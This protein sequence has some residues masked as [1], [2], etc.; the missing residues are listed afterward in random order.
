MQEFVC[1]TGMILKQIPIAEYD[2][3]VCILTKERGKIAAFARGARKPN[4]RLAAATNP[5]C[6]GTFKLY[7]GRDSYT[8]ADAEIQNYF[9][10]L[11]TDY[12]GAYYGMYFA[13]VADYYTRE[14]NDEK[15]MLKL[16]YQSLRALSA[17]SLSRTL[18]KCIYELKAIAVNGEFPG[19][20]TDRKLEESTVYALRYIEN[21]PV[22]K[23]YTFTVT[24]S[25]L[26]ELSKVAE[27]YRKRFMD[28]SF[29]S[30]EILKTL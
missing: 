13:E 24:A 14:N 25:V 12:E 6:F 20:P 18:V 29:K 17:P 26:T 9:E 28:R 2:R 1:V 23:L 11:M 30:L 7:V 4:S 8:M 22:E 15:E 16:L 27:D 5:F 19:I 21:S 3:R 10:E